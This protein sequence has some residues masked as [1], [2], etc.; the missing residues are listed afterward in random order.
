MNLISSDDPAQQIRYEVLTLRRDGSDIHN[1]IPAS[2]WEQGG[3]HVNWCADSRHISM[4]LGGFGSGLRF[5]GTDYRGDSFAALTSHLPGSGH[6][7]VVAAGRYILTDAYETES[8]AAADHS[9]PLRWIDTGNGSERVLLRT[10]SR[11]NPQPTNVLRVDP[12][13]V[14]DR[15]GRYVVFNG[16]ARAENTRRVFI[17]DLGDLCAV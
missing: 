15:S 1:A 10:G 3:H 9:V 5:V 2:R 14:F 16:V 6:P 7:T 12:H 8:M 4:N 11:T 13:P 17:A